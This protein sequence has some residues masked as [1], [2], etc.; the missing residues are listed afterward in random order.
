M[1]NLSRGSWRVPSSRDPAYPSTISLG[2][3]IKFFIIWR[4]NLPDAL[5]LLAL[6]R[7]LATL[8]LLLSGQRGQALHLLDIRNI[9]V[10]D[11][12]LL[13]RFGDLHKQSRPGYQVPELNLP[14]YPPSP[15]LCVRLTYIAYLKRTKP[16]RHTSGLFLATQKPHGK[17]SRDTLSRWVKEV[18]RLSGVDLSIF[19]PHSIRGAST[20]AAAVSKV[21]LASILRTQ[22]GPRKTL[23]ESSIINP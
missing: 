6:S 2:M 4:D 18:L 3:W 17:V 14:A 22:G 21:P 1:K 7:K 13:I 20:S 12:K 16:L 11:N 23:S 8:L 19:T 10:D 9:Q 5:S 15:A